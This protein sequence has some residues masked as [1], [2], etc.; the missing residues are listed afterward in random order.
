MWLSC[1]GRCTAEFLRRGEPYFRPLYTAVSTAF[2]NRTP[3]EVQMVY[4]LNIRTRHRRPTREV[5]CLAR[6][7]PARQPQPPA[8][9]WTGPWRLF[10]GVDTRT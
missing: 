4:V 1:F 7:A 3:P 9:I 10:T 8:T 2:D 5:A 6:P